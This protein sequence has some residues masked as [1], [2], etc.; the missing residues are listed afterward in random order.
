MKLSIKKLLREGLLNEYVIFDYTKVL[1]NKNH[2]Q[3]NFNVDGL[4]YGVYLTH[5]SNH[6]E[7]D[8]Y[9]LGFGI[10]G[11]VNSATRVGKNLEHLNS[12][13]YT[14]DQIVEN[15]VKE[16]LIRKI[17]FSGARE[18]SDSNIPFIDP[19]RLKAYLRFVKA[20]YPNAKI[21]KNRLGNVTIDMRSLYPE[22]FKGNETR[23]EL[24][25]NEIKRISD[26]DPNDWRLEKNFIVDDG[27][28][29]GETDAITNSKLGPMFIG[30]DS[31]DS[32]NEHVLNWEIF[33]TGESD[34]KDFN[35]FNELL[36]FLKVKFK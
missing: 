30:V 36:S 4:E 27:R 17:E 24:F 18:S 29:M 31:S 28:L 3:Y 26:E 1:D 22:L 5:Y 20:K 34:S 14:V 15:V 21:D 25:V 10:V 35:S 32:F 8:V 6:H 16:K 13:L 9:E 7:H 2:I 23:H 19:L 11:D 33:D 12:V